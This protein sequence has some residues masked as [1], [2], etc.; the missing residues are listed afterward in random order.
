MPLMIG[1]TKDESALKLCERRQPPFYV[2]SPPLFSVLLERSDVNLTLIDRMSAEEM[3]ENLTASYSGFTNHPLIAQGCK[4]EYVWS[5]IDPAANAN[6]L[7]ESMLSVSRL[8]TQNLAT[9]A[10]TC[11]Q[12]YSHF[13][14][15]IK[16][17]WRHSMFGFQQV[18]ILV[19]HCAKWEQ[20][21]CQSY[22]LH[23]QIQ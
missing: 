13:W 2:H 15:C 23:T 11:F 10:N 4:H 9:L 8:H 14:V 18:F 19:L 17:Y 5:K 7:Y 1:T 21:F 12:M 16:V 20:I 3:V 6:D 22:S